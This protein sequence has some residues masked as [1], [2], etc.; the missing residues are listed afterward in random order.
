[1]KQRLTML[2][3][4]ISFYAQQG[5]TA[6]ADAAAAVLWKKISVRGLV[7]SAEARGLKLEAGVKS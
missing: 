5:N 7:G 1:M 6:A 4:W 3:A 2:E